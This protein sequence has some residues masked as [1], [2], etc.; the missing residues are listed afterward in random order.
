[1]VQSPFKTE[2]KPV[3]DR[4]LKYLDTDISAV[5]AIAQAAINVELFTIPL[6]MTAL[7]S[8][9]G[10]HPINAKD[11]DYYKGRLWPGAA[12]TAEPKNTNEKAFNIVFSVF[13]Q[14][15]LHLQMASNIASTIGVQPSFT[16]PALQDDKHGWTCYGDDK[17]VIPHI[18]DLKDTSTYKEVKVK[19]D[20]LNKEQ[21]KLFLAIEQPEEDAQKEVPPGKYFPPPPFENWKPEYTEKYLPMF[22]TIGWLYHCYAS[23]LSIEYS[24]GKT[25][26]DKICGSVQRDM[27]NYQ[28]PTSHPGKEYP[29]LNTNDDMNF[30]VNVF[31][32]DVK[33]SMFDKAIDMMSA[34]TDQGEGSTKSSSLH[35]RRWR[36]NP[37]PQEVENRYRPS[38]NAMEYDYPG[39]NDSGKPA[40]SPIAEARS[41]KSDLT[42]YE[43]FEKVQ[44]LL[45]ESDF[46]TW[47]MWHQAG[48]KWTADML[49]APD[50]DPDKA[51]TN[52]PKPD[53]VAGALN[54]LK[55]NPSKPPMYDTFSKVAVGA[56]AGIT[57][58]LDNYW[59]NPSVD[60]PYPSMVGAGDR[61]SICWAVFGKVPD[62]SQGIGKQDKDKLYHACQGL[63]LIVE[64]GSE[65]EADI[66][67]FHSCRGSNECRA[68]G[69]CGF[70][71]LDSGGGNCSS[72][73]VTKP[74]IAKGGIAL[75]GGSSG[76]N[77]GDYS[78]PSDN[79]CK[80]FGGCAVPISQSQ[81][82]PKDGEML[83]YD[84]VPNTD[85]KGYHSVPIKKDG[86]QETIPFKKGENVYHT[87]W[88]AY[89][90]VM[91][92]R[93]HQVGAPPT[94]SDLRLAFPPST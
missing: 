14:E 50:Y 71:Q 86:T 52:I 24:D 29:R 74:T 94:P 39:Y 9:K 63:N 53:E 28:N 91:K 38:E 12:P 17:T 77:F 41:S 81:L 47:D 34:I 61:V 3:L 72:M 60:F 32:V 92:H 10:T 68:Q 37:P 45:N 43:R 49:K 42:H 7:Y 35:I 84:F 11:V 44:E 30:N 2:I 59:Q 16:S 1:M 22:G 87:A 78:A 21:I 54:N 56:I 58:G 82:Y 26:W 33:E 51:P 18:I 6:Y 5:R 83:L 40:A 64:P 15:M 36:K 20:S 73:R 27:F 76:S 65:G 46:M 85:G 57:T 8:I 62:L 23:Y 31:N 70:A 66:T 90:K 4:D 69:G 75:C 89:Q 55:N 13:V 19:L 80:T 79:K 48:N 88:L 67:V 25:L 93:G